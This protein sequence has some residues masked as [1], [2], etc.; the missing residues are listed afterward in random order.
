VAS[1]SADIE[2][3]TERIYNKRDLLARIFPDWQPYFDWTRR[4][5]CARRKGNMFLSDD[6]AAYGV[7]Y[8][9]DAPTSRGLRE[10]LQEQE[11]LTA[12][13]EKFAAEDGCSPAY[14]QQ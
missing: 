4:R 6:A 9:V 3:I 2:I 12:N 14:C 5:W 13:M 8:H 11:I 7:A 1:L 10:R